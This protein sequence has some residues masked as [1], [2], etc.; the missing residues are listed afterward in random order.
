MQTKSTEAKTLLQ[1][2]ISPIMQDQAKVSILRSASLKKIHVMEAEEEGKNITGL[3]SQA[4][5]DGN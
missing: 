3:P 5:D 1:S 4:L 2:L